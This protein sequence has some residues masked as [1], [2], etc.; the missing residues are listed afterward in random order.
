MDGINIGDFSGGDDGR[1]IQVAVGAGSRADA[2]GLIG[3]ADMQRVFVGL[4]VDRD[5]ADIHLLAGPDNAHGDFPAVGYQDFGE[6]LAGF[7]KE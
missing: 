6:T 7:N 4:G 2:D 3:K 5:G 1:D